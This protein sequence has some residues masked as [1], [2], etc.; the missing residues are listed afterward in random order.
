MSSSTVEQAY[1]YCHDVVRHHYENFPVASIL[2]PRHLRKPV[3]AIYAFARMADDFA[4]E[5]THSS[6]QRRHL[7]QQAKTDLL[8]AAK[9][10]PVD[11][12]VYI[13]LT[14]VLTR[15]PDL[16]EPM[17]NLLTAFNMDVEKQRYADFGEVMEYCRYSANPV[18]RMLLILY[19]KAS[20]KNIAYADAICS[21]LQL[22]NFLQ[23]IE[24]DYKDRDRVYM[25]AD[26]L[27]RFQLTEQDLV[28]G[29]PGIDLAPFMDFQVQRAYRLLQAGAPL[30]IRLMG[31]TGL[32]LRMVI[33]GGWK[34]LQKLHQNRGNILA[35]T[36]L[37]KSDWLWIISHAFSSKYA[38]YLKKLTN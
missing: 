22:I 38:V 37:Q 26:E 27:Q 32:E 31:R 19:N 10:K 25:P 7:L 24:E 16:L 2:L 21:A 36:R 5:G 6:E 3:S 30:G 34:V 14:D 17:L 11:Q 13:A 33:L 4:D 18:G 9:G 12:P 1:H 8:L 29:N 20:T 15:T 35:P 23:D 28:A